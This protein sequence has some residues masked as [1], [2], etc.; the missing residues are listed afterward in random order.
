MRNLC[1]V[2]LQL[3]LGR[4]L[5][6]MS[7]SSVGLDPGDFN[8]LLIGI[9]PCMPGVAEALSRAGYNTLSVSLKTAQSNVQWTVGLLYAPEQ[10]LDY[11]VLYI[12]HDCKNRLKNK[13]DLVQNQ[14]SD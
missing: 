7:S 9:D 10:N 4:R 14:I 3:Y 13:P 12:D 5:V 2:F 6:I 1:S 11:L 8:V